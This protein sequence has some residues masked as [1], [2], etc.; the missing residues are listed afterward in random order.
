MSSY[1][2]LEIS[3]T[4]DLE[5]DVD[6][7]LVTEYQ[8]KNQMN[9]YKLSEKGR[10][11]AKVYFELLE[12]EEKEKIERLKKIWN[13]KTLSELLNYIYLRYD[14]YTT[15]SIVKEKI[16]ADRGISDRLESL[17]GIIPYVSLEEE[18]EKTRKIIREK[19]WNQYC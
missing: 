1:N 14:E 13:A 3:K 19:Q 12:S 17:I 10:K 4:E 5:I 11:I 7:L 16:L 9:K 15:F 18:K 8:R 6:S 2:L